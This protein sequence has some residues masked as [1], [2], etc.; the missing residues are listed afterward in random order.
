MWTGSTPTSTHHYGPDARQVL[1]VYPAAGRGRGTIV[2]IH[3]GGFIQGAKSEAREF[4]GIIG[5]QHARGYGVV[6]VD[7]RLT[8]WTTNLF[9]TAVSD[10]SAAIDWI[11]ERGR[12]LGLDTTRVV[13]AGIS[14]GATI[15]ALIGTAANDPTPTPLGRVAGVDG[16][17]GFAGA[18]DFRNDPWARTPIT[19]LRDT[20]L[21]PNRTNP[22]YIDAASPV[23]HLDR[24][25][26]PGY[27]AH[28]DW[29]NIVPIR[30][31]DLLV[32]AARL[33][34]ITDGLF[35][36]R[37]DTGG[38]DTSLGF[39]ISCRWHLPTCGTNA[40][41]LGAWLDSIDAER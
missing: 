1:D 18:Y 40:T 17:I 13:I 37:V 16:W 4:F 9:P 20:W 3:G 14:A 25:D 38:I 27:V 11:E 39:P 8:T 32:D 2:V 33:N 34:H 26:P 6:A 24:N 21:G 31:L 15:S 30:Q 7:Y 36:D 12:D 19:S 29:D 5:A 23:M 35:V 41:A 22:A 28:G 10:V